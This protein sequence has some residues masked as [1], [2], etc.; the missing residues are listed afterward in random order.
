M[1]VVMTDQAEH[2]IEY[3]PASELQARFADRPASTPDDVGIR[4]PNGEHLR[5]RSEILAFIET[6]HAS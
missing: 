5:T 2:R 4:L 1:L 6:L 3:V